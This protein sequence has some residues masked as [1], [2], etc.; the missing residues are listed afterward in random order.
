MTSHDSLFGLG[1]D[2]E[3]PVTEQFAEP[4]PPREQRRK[5]APAADA[6]AAAMAKVLQD[7]ILQA[8]ATE[9][10]ELYQRVQRAGQVQG[11]E[12]ATDTPTVSPVEFVITRWNQY[13]QDPNQ[14]TRIGLPS[15]SRGQ[16][17]PLGLGVKVKIKVPLG[18][19]LIDAARAVVHTARAWGW[20]EYV[21]RP[22][23][24]SSFTL[25]REIVGDDPATPWRAAGKTAFAV[26]AAERDAQ[27]ISERRKVF[28]AAGLVVKQA[29]GKV[30]VPKVIETVIGDR[31]PEILIDL[32]PG[33]APDAAIR[34]QAVM[35]RMFRSPDLKMVAEGVR[36]RIEL[37]T[38]PAEQLPAM[39]PLWPTTL[40]RPVTPEQ[41]VAVGKRIVIPV[42]VTLRDGKV[43][44]V[45]VTPASTPHGVL[46]GVPGS[47]KSRAVRSWATAWAVAGGWLCIADPK[48][49]E[50][51]SEP[52]PSLVHVA[53]S[54]AAFYRLVYWAQV[55]MKR[56]LAVQEVLKR[57]HS[58]GTPPFQPILV[59]LDETGQL[60]TELS[61]STDPADKA[62]RDELERAL[63]QTLQ[64]GRSVGIHLLII[65]Q[66]ALA[67]SLPGGICQAA[68]FRVSLGRPSEGAAGS[69][70]IDRLFPAV[71]RDEARE[72]G[73]TI[74]TDEPGALILDHGKRPVLARSF[75]GYT[76][77]EEPEDPKFSSLPAEIIES[78][79]ATRTALQRIPA[80]RR[81]GWKPPP[82][83]DEW[84]SLSL[85]AG[86]KGE[87]PTV[88]ELE[89]VWLDEFMP[90]GGV[91]PIPEMSKY[92]PLSDAYEGGF[93]PIDL[94]RH[95]SPK[96]R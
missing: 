83:L 53:T 17:V 8:E 94:G 3:P 63:T 12:T 88:K 24:A 55:E 65:S 89:P 11:P 2:G 23:D 9:L 1:G 66:N 67:A 30:F 29:D 6:E 70:T 16:V 37:R 28:E 95:L 61:L 85:S 19:R 38:K 56:R 13:L 48:G 4:E 5:S 72:L 51:V 69:G 31:G 40:W 90:S 80:V 10:A 7:R 27:G 92:D 76:P 25:T 84:Q 52:L 43:E 20:G 41:A 18:T 71:M 87:W 26:Y 14:V 58:I 79:K 96:T 47:G 15:G 68:S 39:V 44:R 93:D 60:F 91:A 49:G 46:V 42:G 59:I 22:H 78:W 54:R 36:V 62:A 35:A 45:E 50:L 64:L 73:A 86:P 57:R 77:G 74:G 82:G 33:L 34:T 21:T 32:P 75:F 81:F